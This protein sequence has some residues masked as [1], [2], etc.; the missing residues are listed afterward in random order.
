M[1]LTHTR[2][3]R[4]EEDEV[5]AED[6]GLRIMFDGEDEKKRRKREMDRLEQ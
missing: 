2:R 5:L 6:D 1:L 4:N 3:G